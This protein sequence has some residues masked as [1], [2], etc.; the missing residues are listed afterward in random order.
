MATTTPAQAFPV[1][2]AGDEPNIPADILAL[3][4]AIEKRVLGVYNNATD[5]DTKL[6]AP[7]EGQVAYLKD[8]NA[9]TYYDGAAWDAMF[10]TPPEFSSGTVVPSNASGNDGDVFFKV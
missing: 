7:Q 4:T 9:F 6:T 3:A 10:T 5:R 8:T 1:M 2:T